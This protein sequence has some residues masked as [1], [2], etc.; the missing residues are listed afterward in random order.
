MISGTTTTI[1]TAIIGRAQKRIKN[2]TGTTSGDNQDQI[3]RS[4][5]DAFAVDNALSNLDPNK[6]NI[7][8][9]V[10]MR[11]NFVK[12]TDNS[13]RLIGKSIDGIKVQFTKANPYAQAL[14]Y[15]TRRQLW[16]L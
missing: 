11:N 10:T 6:D 4:L 8:G 5:S 14:D 3:I 15:S 7:D 16:Q 12:D 1:V 13:L 2:I 9:A